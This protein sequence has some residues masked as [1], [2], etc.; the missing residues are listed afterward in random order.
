MKKLIPYALGSILL[1]Q[2]CENENGWF[3]EGNRENQEYNSGKIEKKPIIKETTLEN[4]SQNYLPQLLLKTS[5]SITNFNNG[6]IIGTGSGAFVASNMVVT[7]SHVIEN[8]NSIE[9][10]RNSDSKKFIGEIIKIDK[11][12]DVC[13][14]E[15]KNDEV[16][17]FLTLDNKTPDIA[18]E[19][20]VAGSPLGLNGTIT[21]GSVSRIA[22]KDPY[23]FEM[24]QI[25]APISPGSSGGPVINMT[26]ELIGI[27]VGSFV[28]EGIQNINFA[29][30]S[31]YIKFLLDNI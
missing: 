20:M 30:P 23:D 27:S 11:A 7:N 22:K 9:I 2:S 15:I 16:D 28:G 31:K 4:V 5:V 6:K 21:K 17:V 13:I 19:I 3:G 29:V 8:G 14:I 24:I 18:S 1:M 25:T 12:H 10:I 26:G